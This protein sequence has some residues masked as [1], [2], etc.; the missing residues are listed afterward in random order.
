MQLW[1]YRILKMGSL[2]VLIAMLIVVPAGA[3]QTVELSEVELQYHRAGS[4]A[5]LIVLPGAAGMNVAIYQEVL[6]PL[7]TT[8]EAFYL[9]PRGAGGSGEP[10]DGD[11]SIAALVR[12]LEEFREYQELDSFYLL[13]HGYGA[14]VA[15][16][17]ALEYPEAVAGLILAGGAHYLGEEWFV[18]RQAA[19]ERHPAYEAYAEMPMLEQNTNDAV[20]M[21]DFFNWEEHQDMMPWLEPHLQVRLEANAHFMEQDMA[22]FD[23]RDR[24][25]EIQHRVLL[26]WGRY[27]V[28]DP[29]ERAE[30]LQNV[31][32]QA[33]L[34]ILEEAAHLAFLEQRDAFVEAVAQFVQ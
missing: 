11:Y 16:M 14:Q 28:V 30:Q 23:L 17:Y 31:L 15:L 18:E 2:A 13:G 7:E 24:V 29:L 8:V 26:V 4:G 25:Q 19:T 34:V 6:Q 27:D 22:E 32:P 21:L 5:A 12:D 10:A 3:W 20:L 33:E 1:W 9:N